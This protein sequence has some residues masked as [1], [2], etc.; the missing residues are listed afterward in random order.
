MSGQDF[1]P[2]SVK[3]LPDGSPFVYNT[4]QDFFSRLLVS[5]LKSPRYYDC[6]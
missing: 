2:L 5:L 4:D 1:C 3:T 6:G